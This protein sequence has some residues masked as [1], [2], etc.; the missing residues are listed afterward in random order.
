MNKNKFLSY[1]HA[2]CIC[3]AP[4]LL[5]KDVRIWWNKFRLIQTRLQTEF[6][7]LDIQ[8]MQSKIERMKEIDEF[9]KNNS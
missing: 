9:L 2:I 5:W 7:K 3:F 4:P 8:K 1:Y 6:I